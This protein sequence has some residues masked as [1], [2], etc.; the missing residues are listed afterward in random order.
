MNEMSF[1]QVGE[2]TPTPGNDGKTHASTECYNCHKFGHYASNCPENDT[3]RSEISSLQLSLSFTQQFGD[4]I[5]RSWILLDTC[6]TVC[7]GNNKDFI[8][9]L[10]LREFAATDGR[11]YFAHCSILTVNINRAYLMAQNSDGS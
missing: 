8:T 4:V 7:V 1:S 5:K 3:R 6:S 9:N 11:A 2:H 10:R